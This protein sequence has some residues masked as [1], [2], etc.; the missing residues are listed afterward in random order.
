[1]AGGL[2]KYRHL[3]RS[4]AHRQALL[5]NLVTSL[6]KNESIHTT[7]HKAKEAQRLAEKLITLAKRDNEETRR[8]AQGILFTPHLL[9]PKLFGTLKTRYAD[10]PGGY[11][12]VLR[13]EPKKDDQ[14]QSAVLE[15]VDSPMDMRFAMTAAVVARDRELGREHS[16][17]TQRNRNKVTR[18]R[19][20]GDEAFEAMVERTQQLRLSE[21]GPQLADMEPVISQR[22]ERA[23]E[24]LKRAK[25]V[26]S[27]WKPNAN[28]S[29]SQGS[30][31][32]LSA[33]I[34]EPAAKPAEK[35]A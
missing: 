7:W 27:Y 34:G 4:S 35:T 10:R 11:T 6:V 20:D 8:K 31:K 24:N 17:L 30:T 1:M 26:H 32:A 12:R 14:A 21:S 5:R 9:M 25:P 3:S 23:D 13:T 15:F 16:V 2:V 22:A 33:A 29:R 19:K 18:Y 28:V